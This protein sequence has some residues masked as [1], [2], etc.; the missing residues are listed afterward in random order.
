MNLRFRR[1]EPEIMDQPGLDAREHQRALAALARVNLLSLTARSVAVE[2]AAFQV[3]R[4]LPSLRVLDIACGGGDVAR[5]LTRP[6][7]HVD[8]CDLSPTAVAYAH[9]QSAPSGGSFFVHDALADPVPP[10]YDALTCSLFVHHLDTQQTLTLFK[11]F[12]ESDAKLVVISDLE[13]CRA[14]LWSAYLITRLLT[15]SPVVHY[16]GPVSVRAAYT[17]S[18]I[19]R[20]LREAGLHGARLRR[21]W[22]FRW[23]MTWERP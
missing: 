16:D 9:G 20:L 22:P 10:G 17:L 15:R 21:A 13:R 12:R 2:L 3:R 6:G 23:L 18:E 1:L 4:G 14:G 19:A 5:A 8:G 7:W 11:R